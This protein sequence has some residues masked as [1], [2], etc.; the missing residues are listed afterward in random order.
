M[1]PVF[2]SRL[3]NV[4]SPSILKDNMGSNATKYESDSRQHSVVS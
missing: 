3:M 4:M 2:E 1:R